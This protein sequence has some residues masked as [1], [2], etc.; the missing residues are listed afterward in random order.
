[1]II[2]LDQ[3]YEHDVPHFAD[4][5]NYQQLC[6]SSRKKY[7]TELNWDSWGKAFNSI[8]EKILNQ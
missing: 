5:E 7:E 4:N 8:A 6:I 1:M 2:Q 3:S